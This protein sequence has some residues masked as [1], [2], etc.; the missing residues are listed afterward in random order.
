M[1][2]RHLGILPGVILGDR[3][4]QHERFGLGMKL[5]PAG[6]PNPDRPG[7]NKLNGERQRRVGGVF[8]VREFIRIHRFDH[9]QHVVKSLPRDILRAL[10]PNLARVGRRIKFRH[11][12][13]HVI[14][15]GKI[16]KVPAHVHRIVQQHRG[17]V[18]RNQGKRW[19]AITCCSQPDQRRQDFLCSH[20]IS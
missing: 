10:I 14:E 6:R 2:A 12:V 18:G 7:R 9:R 20:K 3:S 8:P 11:P 4:G 13:G 16:P 17:R 15:I 1:P 19:Q 5:R